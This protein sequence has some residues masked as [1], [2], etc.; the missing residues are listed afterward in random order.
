MKLYVGSVDFELHFASTLWNA[1]MV[2]IWNVDLDEWSNI[3]IHEFSIWGHPWFW[4]LA[5]RYEF[6]QI[7]KLS[8]PNLFKSKV[9]I[10]ENVGLDEWNKLCIHEFSIW[11]HPGLGQSVCLWNPVFWLWSNLVK[12]P[13]RVLQMENFWIPSC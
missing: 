9:T 6:F 4:K 12:W 13:I 10:R 1:K 8:G 3:D 7:S 5:F 11:G 2:C